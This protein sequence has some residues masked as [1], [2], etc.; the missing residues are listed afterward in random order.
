MKWEDANN[1]CYNYLIN[2]YK[3]CPLE[4]KKN[5]VDLEDYYKTY[6]SIIRM[7][8]T[9]IASSFCDI[10]LKVPVLFCVD[11]VT[12][13]ERFLADTG[14]IIAY[15]ESLTQP[16]DLDKCWKCVLYKEE[17]VDPQQGNQSGQNQAPPPPEQ[18][19]DIRTYHTLFTRILNFFSTN[20]QLT[21]QVHNTLKSYF[22]QMSTDYEFSKI[23]IDVDKII[24]PTKLPGLDLISN[25]YVYF[26][27]R[28]FYKEHP[29]YSDVTKHHIQLHNDFMD[30]MY[31]A[32]LNNMQNI[33]PDIPEGILKD[34]IIHW[35]D[36][37][38]KQRNILQVR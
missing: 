38:H 36:V 5:D 32:F 16:D 24:T 2:K 10:S 21:V 12:D 25:G 14:S 6:N 23:N 7:T 34:K 26:N 15:I 27:S 17:F 22:S 35:I 37:L 3:D 29:Q 11:V 4:I 20:L 33:L 28:I 30:N 1:I 9:Y 13:C 31:N 19:L 18:P 8:N